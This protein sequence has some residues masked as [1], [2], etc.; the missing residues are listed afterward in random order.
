MLVQYYYP[1]T[2]SPDRL[3]RY[4]ADGWFRGAN[5]L[6]RSQLVWFEED[7]FS[8]INIRLNVKE[9]GFRKS[10]RKLMN[11]NGRNF[12][13]E[14]GPATVNDAK[15]QL[16]QAHKHRFKGFVFQ[17]LTQFLYSDYWQ[18]V[19][20]TY[21]ICVY[22]EERLVAVS[23]F[24]VGKSSVAS[25]IGL[26]DPAYHKFSLGMYTMLLEIEFAQ[27]E[28]KDFYYPGYVLDTYP[29]FD[30]KLR[31]GSMEYYDW[32]GKW[33]PIEEMQQEKLIGNLL[34]KEMHSLQDYLAIHDIESNIKLNPFFSIG[35]LDQIEEDFLQSSIFLQIDVDEASNKNLIVEFVPDYNMYTLCWVSEKHNYHEYFDTELPKGMDKADSCMFTYLDCIAD[36]YDEAEVVS[37]I[38]THLPT[39]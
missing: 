23:Y 35:Y 19:F 38:R 24:D 1:Q 3:D 6:Y 25:I 8:V 9:Y 5:M 20:D 10:L 14:I 31:L 21:E 29:K 34:K 32:H 17:T 26:H 13:V 22:D 28:G 2:L 39:A 30:Y 12:K 33:L 18:S 16:Y 27:N 7:I 36:C 11:R 15:E 4:R 37:W